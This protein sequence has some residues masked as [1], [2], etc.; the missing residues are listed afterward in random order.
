MHRSMSGLAAIILLAGGCGGGSSTGGAPPTG[1]PAPSPTSSPTPAPSPTPSVSIAFLHSYADVLP[2]GVGSAKVIKGGDGNF[3]SL[4]GHGGKLSCGTNGD[5][6]CGAIFRISPDGQPTIFFDFSMSP[7]LGFA[8]NSLIRGSDGALYGTASNGGPKGTGG[9]IFRI[10]LSGVYSVLHS[11]GTDPRDGIIPLNITEASDGNFYGITASGGENYCRI[12]PGTASNCGTVFRITPGGDF[13][14]LHSFGSS[15][16]DGALPQGNLTEGSDGNLYGATQLGG[17]NQCASQP[18]DCGT[19]FKISKTGSAS[20]VHS[21]GSSGDD[22][23]APSGVIVR[24]AGD[25][26]YGLTLSGGGRSCGFQYGC[27]TVFRYSSGSGYSLVYRF[28]NI[29]RLDGSG[30]S[31]LLLSSDGNLYGTTYSNGA[32]QCDSCG[33]VFRLSKSGNLTTLYSFGPV[34]STPT[35][36]TDISQ[37]SDGTLYGWNQDANTYNGTFTVFKLTVR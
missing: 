36:P 11:F 25:E 9:V 5:L 4:V 18:N 1:A 16:G 24:G 32:L 15:P 30:P 28:G 29:N 13:T 10:T 21:F 7:N 22:G 2:D 37:A 33:S 27:G 34:T 17:Q 14:T 6:A 20:I 23:I 19:L 3:Y 35:S 12:I 31:S 8:P 26:I